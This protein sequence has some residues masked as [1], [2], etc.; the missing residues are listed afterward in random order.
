MSIALAFGLFL[1]GAGL[2][3]LS[4]R[5]QQ[6]AVRRQFQQELE[7]QIKQALF[8][9][10]SRRRL[11][12]SRELPSGGPTPG[13]APPE[14]IATGDGSRSRQTH[15]ESVVPSDSNPLGP[16]LISNFR[17]IPPDVGSRQELGS[18]TSVLD[19]SRKCE[20]ASCLLH[21]AQPG[22]MENNSNASFFSEADVLMM[23]SMHI[24]L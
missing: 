21:F 10:M 7:T 16:S 23:Q 8:G 18:E 15:T 1:S 5:I 20:T 4:T 13:S 11:L 19:G 22:S 6:T 3:A 17:P 14:A 24:C 9:G 12:N 2:G